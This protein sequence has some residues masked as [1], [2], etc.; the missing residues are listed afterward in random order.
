MSTKIYDFNNVNIIVNGRFITGYFEGSNIVI[1]RNADKYIKSI[2]VKGEIS[3]AKNNDKSGTV[4]FSLE[5]NSPTNDFLTQIANSDDFAEVSVIDS[6]KDG[7]INIASNECVIMRPADLTRG[8]EISGREWTIDV[9]N[10][11]F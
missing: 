11:T 6:N 5:H 3:Y 9:P 8:L 7:K 1:T 2:G 4:T 10:I